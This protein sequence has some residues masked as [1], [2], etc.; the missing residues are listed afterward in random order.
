MR[1]GVLNSI[2]DYLQ[3]HQKEKKKK[4]HYHG[5]FRALEEHKFSHSF[6]AKTLPPLEIIILIVLWHLPVKL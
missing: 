3:V 4:R 2:V 1:E 5:Q 6:L